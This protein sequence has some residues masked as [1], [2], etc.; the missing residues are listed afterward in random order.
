MD[1]S[2]RGTAERAATA[3]GDPELAQFHSRLMQVNE[4]NSKTRDHIE[5]FLSR[6]VGRQEA[7]PASEGG[8]GNPR[9]VPS[10]AI[11]ALGELIDSAMAE[12]SRLSQLVDEL[13]RI[14]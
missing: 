7:P 4:S 2:I 10:G 14:A 12:A 13:D 3:K 5:R 6:A 11:A 8:R 9:P 1:H